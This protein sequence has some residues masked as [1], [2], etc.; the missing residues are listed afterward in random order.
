MRRELTNRFIGFG[1]GSSQF[2]ELLLDPAD[3][4]AGEWT[5]MEIKGGQHDDGPSPSWV[6]RCT[7]DDG[8]PEDTLRFG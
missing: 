3:D 4:L 1:C 8:L 2:V 7:L 6:F 5:Q